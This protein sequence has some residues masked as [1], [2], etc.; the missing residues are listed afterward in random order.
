MVRVRASAL[1]S[2]RKNPGNV[3]V[4]VALQSCARL[5]ATAVHPWMNASHSPGYKAV[6]ALKAMGYGGKDCLKRVTLN[7]AGG[8]QGAG[9]LRSPAFPLSSACSLQALEPALRSAQVA[10]LWDVRLISESRDL[11][12]KIKSLQLELNLLLC[13]TVQCG[14]RRVFL[15][16]ET[17]AAFSKCCFTFEALAHAV[18]KTVPKL[19]WI[20]SWGT[21][22]R[23]E[24]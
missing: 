5:K 10:P 19:Q 11:R 7:C 2:F 8:S 3:R 4:A 6:C 18:I 1:N 24:L 14:N 17:D 15:P 16:A 12:G 13:V 23:K 21:V 9:H 22:E 20:A